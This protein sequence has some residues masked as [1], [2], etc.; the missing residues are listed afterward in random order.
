MPAQPQRQKAV[1]YVPFDGV[2]AEQRTTSAGCNYLRIVFGTGAGVAAEVDD[3][4]S[5][6][7]A[8]FLFIPSKR[9]VLAGKGA[10]GCRRA[11]GCCFACLK[12]DTQRQRLDR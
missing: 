11:S 4:S 7:D 9:S 12:S 2:L 10:P 8:E 3:P 5:V 6:I 1:G